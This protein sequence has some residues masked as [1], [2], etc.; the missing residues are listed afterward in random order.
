MSYII[1]KSREWMTI[2][3]CVN[4]SGQSIPGFYLFKGKRQLQ[5]YILK[6]EQG[7]CMTAQQHACV[8]KEYFLNWLHHFKRSVLGG[9]SPN[10]IHFLIFDGHGNHV[11]LPTI[12]EER[13]LGIDL[14]TLLAH[15]SHKL[16]PLDVSVF[17]PFKT[18]FKSERAAWIARFPN[19]EIRREGLAEIGSKSLAKALTIPNIVA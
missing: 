10:N 9:V 7:A 13:M 5:N 12:Q 15:T 1:L 8:T 19:V 16:Q 11:A 4:A 17:S 14:L 18:Y 3:C 2:L 6:C